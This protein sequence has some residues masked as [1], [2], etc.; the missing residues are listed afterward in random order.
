[1]PFDKIALKEA[2]TDLDAKISQTHRGRESNPGGG[3]QMAAP[4]D[5]AIHSEMG[6]VSAPPYSTREGAG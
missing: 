3:R 4:F 2:D 6:T 1:M 5:A